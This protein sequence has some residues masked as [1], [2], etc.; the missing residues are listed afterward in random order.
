MRDSIKRKLAND[1][2]LY[3][4]MS[5]FIHAIA[6]CPD[7]SPTELGQILVQSMDAVDEKQVNDND[8]ED[9]EF[10]RTLATLLPG[11]GELST[12]TSIVET[13][14]ARFKSEEVTD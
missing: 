5:R 3:A 9:N 8:A 10:A 6:S 13:I 11:A 4:G 12:L 1:Q 14:I 2:R 7:A